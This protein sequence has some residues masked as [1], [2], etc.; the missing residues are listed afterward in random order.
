VAQREAFDDHH[1]YT[2]E[3]AAGLIMRGR[4]QRARAPDHRKG[5]RA[6]DR[7]RLLEALLQRRTPCASLWLLR[8]RMKCA[9]SC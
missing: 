2:A 8:K 3:E 7:G 1:C 6:D 4:T 9:G 5:P